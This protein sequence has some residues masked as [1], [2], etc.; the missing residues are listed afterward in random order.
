MR[1][2]EIWNRKQQ[3]QYRNECISIE[4]NLRYIP[5]IVRSGPSIKTEMYLYLSH[6]MAPQN[7]IPG[8]NQMIRWEG[9]KII[10]FSRQN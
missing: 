6:G 7:R 10:S 2:I 3:P 5:S 8:T 9:R 4:G 1:N